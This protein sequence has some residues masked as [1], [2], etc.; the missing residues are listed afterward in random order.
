MSLDCQMWPLLAT[1]A[2]SAPC[3]G[4]Q[5]TKSV[6]FL[7]IR[8]SSLETDVPISLVL[9]ANIGLRNSYWG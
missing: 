7:K 5:L 3:S 4:R 1:E 9:P 2:S 8:P 6:P